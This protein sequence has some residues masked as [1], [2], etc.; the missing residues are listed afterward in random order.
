MANDYD[1]QD[2]PFDCEQNRILSSEAAL[3]AAQGDPAQ[4]RDAQ[5]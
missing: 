5:R 3:D 2:D 1:G 4:S